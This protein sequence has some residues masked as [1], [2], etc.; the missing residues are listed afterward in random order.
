MLIEKPHVDGL[1]PGFLIVVM[2]VDRVTER[3]L[4]ACL[5]PKVCADNQ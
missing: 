5:G 1:K 3:S 2:N 4:T